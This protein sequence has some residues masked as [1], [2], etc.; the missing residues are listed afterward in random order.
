M[1]TDRKLL[2]DIIRKHKIF[3]AFYGRNKITSTKNDDE[4]RRKKEK[5]GKKKVILAQY[6][7]FKTHFWFNFSKTMNKTVNI[8]KQSSPKS[9]NT[10]WSRL[11]FF[12]L[13]LKNSTS[14]KIRQPVELLEKTTK[15]FYFKKLSQ[16]EQRI[17]ITNS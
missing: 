15:P 13:I 2:I 17:N 7:N 5:T 11:I 3:W 12:Y 10:E 6:E 16:Q 9:N 8:K 4:S 1:K 14:E